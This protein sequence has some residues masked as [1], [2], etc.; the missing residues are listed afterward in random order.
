MFYMKNATP[1]IKPVQSVLKIKKV[2]EDFMFSETFTEKIKILREQYSI[3]LN[4]FPLEEK[5]LEEFRAETLLFLPKQLRGKNEKENNKIARAILKDI[6]R[7]IAIHISPKNIYT[8]FVFKF[9]LFFNEINFSFNENINKFNNLYGLQEVIDFKYW[10]E[11]GIEQ[12]SNTLTEKPIGILLH[13]ET[14]QRDLLDYIKKNFSKEIEPL[15]KQYQQTSLYK[16][17]KTKNSPRK[18][19]IEEIVSKSKGK[20]L[21]EIVKKLAEKSVYI[22]NSNISNRK[23]DLKKKY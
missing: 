9:Y 7:S 3:P 14:T 23:K 8:L 21:K 19:I 13:P 22:D 6:D 1:K 5:T 16:N 4:G 12:K 15:L 20:T 10:Q 17:I 2:L 18:K 11:G